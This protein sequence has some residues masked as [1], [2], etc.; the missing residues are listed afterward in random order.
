[1]SEAELTSNRIFKAVPG[2]AEKNAASATLIKYYQK[3]ADV[4][5]YI[6]NLS[7]D[8]KDKLISI[9]KEKMNGQLV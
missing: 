5:S 9:V 6:M 7:M 1:M 8:E 4:L 2:E 3:N